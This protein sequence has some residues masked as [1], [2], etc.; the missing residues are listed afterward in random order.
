VREAALATATRLFAARG[1]DAT[2]LQAIAD[3]IGATKQAILHHFPSKELLRDAVFDAMLQHWRETMPRLLEASASEDRFDAVLGELRR[4]FAADPDRARLVL[5]EILDRPQ[6]IERLL[7]E[8][9]RGWVALIAGYIRDGQAAGRHHPDLDPEAYLVHVLY[10][11]ISA[12][13]AAPVTHGAIEASGAGRRRFE[14]ELD[15]IA[16]AALFVPR[17]PGA[18][19]SKKKR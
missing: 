8:S 19:T 16:K 14:H 6:E 15:R 3:A 7:R 13:A 4:F 1:F 2:P 10:F 9:V 11:V 18:R 17:D 5:R 12:A